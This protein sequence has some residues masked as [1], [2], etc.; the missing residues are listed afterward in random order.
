MATAR[1]LAE[2]EALGE[3]WVTVMVYYTAGQRARAGGDLDSARAETEH[4]LNIARRGGLRLDIVYGLLA[5][6]QISPKRPACRR[7]R[8]TARSGDAAAG[9]LS[10]RWLPAIFGRAG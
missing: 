10:R 9:R 6:A 3:H 7:R 4:G 2:R 8:R 1:T 5:L